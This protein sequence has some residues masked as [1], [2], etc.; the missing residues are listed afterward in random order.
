MEVCIYN[1]ISCEGYI[2]LFAN[3]KCDDGANELWIS[4]VKLVDG[5]RLILI[6]IH[7]SC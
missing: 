5:R 7:L 4:D 2:S 6:W 3:L 1:V